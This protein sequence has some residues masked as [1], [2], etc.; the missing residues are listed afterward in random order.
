MGWVEMSQDRDGWRALVYAVMNFRIA[1]V[2]GKFLTNWKSVRFCRRNH[3]HGVRSKLHSG[4]YQAL[5]RFPSSV[6]WVRDGC[7]SVRPYVSKTRPLFDGFEKKKKINNW[8]TK[9]K[10]VEKLQGLLNYDME[11]EYLNV[12]K[13][14]CKTTLR[15]ILLRNRKF[16][17]RILRQNQESYFMF[18]YFFV[19][20]CI[21]YQIMWRNV[22]DLDTQNDL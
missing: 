15:R 1:Y 19:E 4:Q 22:V 14:V 8:E 12:V 3:L 17:E 2:A 10:T 6:Y 16:F 9:N 20:I 5:H 11:N 13:H 7:P 18:K 21:V